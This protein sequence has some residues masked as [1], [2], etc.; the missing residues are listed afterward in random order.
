[1]PNLLSA[2]RLCA[3]PVFLWLLL[4]RHEALGAAV[5]LGALGA[6]DWVDG[7]AARR[8]GQVSALGKLLD[9][10]ADRALLL[11]AVAG[12]LVAGAVPAW[13]AA[14]VAAREALVLAGASLVVVSGAERV[15]VVWVGKAG[16]FA[17]MTALPLFLAGHSGVSWHRVAG[18]LAWAAAALGVAGGWVA[19]ARYAPR[20]RRAIAEARRSPAPA[21]DVPAPDR[22]APAVPAPDVPAPAVPPSARVAQ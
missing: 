8:F 13:L 11:A 7:W 5:L 22:P 21:T 15:E 4:G 18:D 3:A 9:P 19:A 12:A 16:T 2:A 10:A 20:V 17:L 1:M 14:V 6:T